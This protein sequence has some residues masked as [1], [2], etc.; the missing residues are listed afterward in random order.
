MLKSDHAAWVTEDHSAYRETVERFLA[1]ELT[2]N[3]DEWRAAGRVDREFWRKAGEYGLLGASTPEEFGGSGAPLSFDAI[4]L[5]S[6]GR[7]GDTSWGF[8]IHNFVTHYILK[9]GDQ[10]QKEKWLPR[11]V[12]GD[13]VAA[14]AM[15]EP[16]AGSDLQA[17]KTTAVKCGD[18]YRLSGAKTFITN[19]AVA[20]LVCVAARTG[21]GGH[22]G[23]SLI[24]LETDGAEGFRRGK[25][26]KKLGMSGQDTVE[27]YFDDVAVPSENLL[28][29]F[30]GNG[31]Y[32]LM[33]Q[34]PWERL[35]IG[36]TALGACELAFELTVEYVTNRQA[37]GKAIFEFQ[38]TRMKLAEMKTK[39]EVTKAFID[40][41]VTL[42][43]Q[44]ALSVE[45]AA[46]AKWW[47]SEIQC[48]IVD[49]CLQLHGGYGYMDEYQISRMYADARVQK[50]YGGT[51]EIMK[52]LIARSIASVKK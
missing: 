38:N 44:D 3:V 21:E 23:I 52:E 30:E 18:I 19:G 12:S 51:N 13:L 41:C 1:S 40:R 6:Q 7:T 25:N 2:P 24:M 9:F 8:G 26:L 37:F 20:D 50:I 32:Q 45:A 4:T 11:L 36:L 29:G 22:S 43:D 31:F 47:G 48:E 17:L 16:G 10:K 27:M 15:T 49:E 35:S 39:I 46:M 34:L 14:L 28:G 5:L 42:L 33:N